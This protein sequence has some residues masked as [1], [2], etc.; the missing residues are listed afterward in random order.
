MIIPHL[1]HRSFNFQRFLASRP[2]FW[3]TS[4]VHHASCPFATPYLL[5]AM[6]SVVVT[7]PS[8]VRILRLNHW[9]RLISISF[10]RYILRKLHWNWNTRLRYLCLQR[11]SL[12]H[13]DSE[14]TSRKSSAGNAKFFLHPFGF[15]LRVNASTP[16][17]EIVSCQFHAFFFLP[18]AIHM[19]IGWFVRVRYDSYSAVYYSIITFRM[20]YYNNNN[21]IYIYIL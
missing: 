9:W 3:C 16:G 20:L 8:D 19:S 12:I 17:E 7:S 18:V 21:N 1:I 13:F 10:V 14:L 5:D 15:D 4:V 6:R 11:Y 2:F